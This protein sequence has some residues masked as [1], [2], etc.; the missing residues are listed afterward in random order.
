MKTPT[1]FPHTSPGLEREGNRDR[2]PT[3]GKSVQQL[4]P[5]PPTA[6]ERGWGE[7]AVTVRSTFV[8]RVSHQT[9][10]SVSLTPGFSP[11]VY[12]PMIRPTAS[13]VSAPRPPPPARI[14]LPPGRS[15]RRLFHMRRTTQMGVSAGPEAREFGPAALGFGPAGSLRAPPVRT[16][17]ETPVD[18]FHCNSHVAGSAVQ[19]N[20]SVSAMP[21]H[22]TRTFATPPHPGTA[23]TLLLRSAT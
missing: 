14:C 12:A 10:S 8:C 19:F 6:E 1:G 2:V 17:G 4:N 13:A 11:A 5:S 18:T 16:R 22:P 23:D 7:E 15:G 20:K 21:G 9:L 3:L